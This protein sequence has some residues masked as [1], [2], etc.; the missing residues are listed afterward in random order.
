M[1]VNA[2]EYLFHEMRYLTG[3]LLLLCLDADGLLFSVNF[4][5]L[6]LED[7]EEEL[8]PAPT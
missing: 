1:M 3:R 4:D 8:M 5:L 6:V 7:D 2:F